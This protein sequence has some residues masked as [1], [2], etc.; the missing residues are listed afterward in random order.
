MFQI[1]VFHAYHGGTDTARLI[2]RYSRRVVSLHHRAI[3]KKGAEVKAGT[4]T[5]SADVDVPV[6]TGQIDM[7]A[8][9]RA[10]MKAGTSVYYLEDESSTPWEHIPQ[11]LA[12]LKSFK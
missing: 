12:F 5:A 7:P 3:S 9:L 11:S 10:A 2:A 6:G 4:A 8:V 1:D